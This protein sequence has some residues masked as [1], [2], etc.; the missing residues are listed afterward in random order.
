M[1]SLLIV[2]GREPIEGLSLLVPGKLGAFSAA[3]LV[4]VLSAGASVVPAVVYANFF[5]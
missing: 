3:I 5:V 4:G 1:R 2:L